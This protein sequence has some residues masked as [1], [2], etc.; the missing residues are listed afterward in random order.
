MLNTIPEAVEAIKA[1]KI[2]IVV[3]DDDRENEGDFLIAS[4]YATPEAI[5][6][7]ARFGRAYYPPACPSTGTRPYGKK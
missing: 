6:F 4:R 7:M 2:I 5:N 3:D 1:G